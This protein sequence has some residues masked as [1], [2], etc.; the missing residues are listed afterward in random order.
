MFSLGL[1]PSQAMTWQILSIMDLM[2]VGAAAV[3]EGGVGVVVGTA[4][5]AESKTPVALTSPTLMRLHEVGGLIFLRRC[6]TLV[7]VE[8]PQ[9][10]TVVL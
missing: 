3:V 7:C 10:H 1:L 9:A 8:L 5:E 2:V 4:A 6:H